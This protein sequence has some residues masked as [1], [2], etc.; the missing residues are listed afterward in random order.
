MNFL[1]AF[2]IQSG[3]RGIRGAEEGVSDGMWWSKH[4]HTHTNILVANENNR[5]TISTLHFSAIA[6][7]DS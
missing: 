5:D 2:V 3:M 1:G 7:D 6:G 4:T